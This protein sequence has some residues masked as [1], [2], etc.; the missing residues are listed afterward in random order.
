MWSQRKSN[1]N[2]TDI[3][4]SWNNNKPNHSVLIFFTYKSDTP[5]D[6]PSQHWQHDTC[7]PPSN[8]ASWVH[9]GPWS[10]QQYSFL[11][12]TSHGRD[13]HVWNQLNSMKAP[14][15]QGFL[16]ERLSQ[17]GRTVFLSY[18]PKKTTMSRKKGP[19]QKVR[20]VF[21]PLHPGKL[22]WK[23]WNLTITHVYKGKWS[24][25]PPGNYVPCLS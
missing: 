25:K 3:F 9:P 23:S 21:Q 18:S 10:V 7:A 19:F 22:T 14:V 2:L 12:I 4:F 17:F 11:I 20:L 24:S 6:V 1:M 13:F 8:H 16:Y 5:S 15:D